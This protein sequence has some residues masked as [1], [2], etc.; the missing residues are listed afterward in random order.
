MAR[1]ARQH[2]DSD[3][4]SGPDAD[5]ESV[6]RTIVLTKLTTQPRSRA[7]LV[8][9]LA[10]RHV[11]DDVARRV[12]DRLE[13]VGLVDDAAFAR[14]WVESRQAGR[15][16]ARRVLVQEL[17]RKGVDDEVARGALDEIDPAAEEQAARALV[18]RRMRSMRS[19]SPEARVRRLISMLARKGYSGNVVFRVVRDEVEASGVGDGVVDLE[20]PPGT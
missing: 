20:L 6:A 11:P 8:D 13:E 4:G 1:R 16:L 9:L 18:R 2:D 5:P 17:R 19:I 10:K 3:P 7:E 12:L 15:G 14:A